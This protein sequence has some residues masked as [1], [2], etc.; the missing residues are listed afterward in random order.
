MVVSTRVVMLMA[1]NELLFCVASFLPRKDPILSASSGSL[2]QNAQSCFGVESFGSERLNS[3]GFK[4]DL[5]SVA[6]QIPSR[7][8]HSSHHQPSISKAWRCA[9]V[10]KED[11]QAPI[12]QRK[13]SRRSSRTMD[14]DD[15]GKGAGEREKL[16][17]LPQQTG[18]YGSTS[19]TAPGTEL[20]HQQE[21]GQ[22]TDASAGMI[23]FEENE[24]RTIKT[25]E[26]LP[27]VSEECSD[28]ED[29]SCDDDDDE[30]EAQSRKSF[31]LGRPFNRTF[32]IAST[33][34]AS[35]FRR[36]AIAPKTSCPSPRPSSRTSLWVDR[37]RS[38]PTQSQRFSTT[39]GRA[40]CAS[41]G[42]SSSE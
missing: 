18:Q 23:T 26:I 2:V 16:R 9:A 30:S 39:P 10:R 8:E 13:I 33:S 27:G 20:Y 37:G 28:D 19:G 17:L 40:T 12:Q 29:D 25:T 4:A 24:D 5:N 34:C 21:S 36:F 3:A 38:R 42:T 31:H 32:V 41:S 14:S 35:P 11:K 15:E 22:P 6:I 7:S 1:R